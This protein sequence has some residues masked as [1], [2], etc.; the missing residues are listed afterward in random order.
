MG[1]VQEDGADKPG[2]ITPPPNLIPPRQDTQTHTQRAPARKRELPVF[3]P[4]TSLPAPGA[5]APKP[6]TAAPATP[7]APAAPEHQSEWFLELPGPVRIPVNG[8]LLLGRNPV[9]FAEWSN[10]TLV[11]IDDPTRSVSKTHAL[12]ELAPRGLRI[13]DLHSTNGV[14]VGGGSGGDGELEPGTAAVITDDAVV[15]LGRFELRVVHA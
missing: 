7:A 4:P 13:I 2:F 1:D 6:V 3:L 9:R 14:A 5:P 8:A 10:A 11:P 15:W 12:I